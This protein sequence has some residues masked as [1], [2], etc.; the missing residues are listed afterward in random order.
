MDRRSFFKGMAYASV[1]LPSALSLAHEGEVPAHPGSEPLNADENTRMLEKIRN[2][3]HDFP[4][5]V[6]LPAERRVLVDTLLQRITKVRNRIGYGHF[7]LIAFDELLKHAALDPAIG[8]FTREEVEFIEEIFF[9]DAKAYGF[10]GEKV[11]PSLTGKI[12]KRKVVKIA[13]SGHYLFRGRPEALYRK[14]QKDIGSDIVLTSGIR[15]VVKQLDLFLTKAVS[16]D[17]NLSRASRSLAPPGHSFH[18]TSDFDVG[19]AG[20]GPL[21]FTDDFAGTDVYKRLTDL[22]YVDIRYTET[23][24]FGVRFEPWHIKVS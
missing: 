8:A 23:N 20:F 11:S 21:N 16:C 1:A 2:F 10:F 3:D 15:G 5:D 7:N 24:S 6:H 13:G 9:F 22:G 18:G 12:D 4:E 14:V 19:K 17:G